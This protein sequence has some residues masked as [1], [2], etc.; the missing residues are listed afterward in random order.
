MCVALEV[1]YLGGA[2]ARSMFA[3]DKTSEKL[4]NHRS[5]QSKIGEELRAQYDLPQEMP[6]RIFTLLIQLGEQDA[7][8]RTN[9]NLIH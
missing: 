4:V 6:H 7:K 9:W 5:I 1:G 8:H 2:F 3:R